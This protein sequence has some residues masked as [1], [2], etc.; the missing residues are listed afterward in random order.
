M[1]NNSDK[2][3]PYDPSFAEMLNQHI[4]RKRMNALKSS[5]VREDEESVEVV[6]WNAEAKPVDQPSEENMS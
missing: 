5:Q 4:L 2:T 3:I 1:L 6:T